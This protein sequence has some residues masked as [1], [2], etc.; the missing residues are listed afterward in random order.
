MD[1]I[2]PIIILIISLMLF[3]KFRI[4]LILEERKEEE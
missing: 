2:M 1:K 4:S 3:T